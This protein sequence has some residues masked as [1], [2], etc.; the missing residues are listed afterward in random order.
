MLWSLTAGLN[1]YF[2][3]E[4]KETIFALW[5]AERHF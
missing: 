4:T 1:Q 2:I 3:L 5:V